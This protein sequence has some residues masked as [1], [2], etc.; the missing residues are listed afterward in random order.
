[1]SDLRAIPSVDRLLAGAGPLMD[2]HGRAAVTDAL[3]AELAD[4]LAPQ[5]AFLAANFDA[6][7]N[8][9]LR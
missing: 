6:A 2:R 1:M 4:R 9:A 3:R 7:F 5:Y 8:A